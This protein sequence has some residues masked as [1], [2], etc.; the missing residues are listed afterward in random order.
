[1]TNDFSLSS[2]NIPYGVLH[3]QSLNKVKQEKNKIIF[4]F[5]IEL[6]P[7]NYTDI[8]F[9][10]RYKDCKHCD[11][12][13][14]LDEEPINY[15]QFTSCPKAN[16]RF[17]GISFNREKFIDVINNS[18]A[19]FVECSATYNELMIELCINFY[20]AHKKYRKYRKYDMCN[21]TLNAKTVCW[22]WY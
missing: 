15:F 11:M 14:E 8:D 3:D 22:N 21:I 17:K 16:G 2:I 19:T 10:N 9:Y 5:D 18:C 1:M 12:I 6:Y 13:I 20:N 7:Q 4:T